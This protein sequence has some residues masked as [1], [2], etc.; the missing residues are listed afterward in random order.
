M[1]SVTPA[2]CPSFSPFG[3][4]FNIASN[5]ANV[6][7]TPGLPRLINSECLCEASVPLTT[8]CRLVTTNG[9][10]QSGT[11]FRGAAGPVQGSLAKPADWLSQSHTVAL[12]NPAACHALCAT[13]T[14]GPNRPCSF[15]EFVYMS[16]TT[17]QVTCEFVSLPPL[18]ISQRFVSQFLS[19]PPV[20]PPSTPPTP[21][22]NAT[23]TTLTS[24]SSLPTSTSTTPVRPTDPTPDPQPTPADPETPPTDTLPSTPPPPTNSNRNLVTG[25]VVAGTLT[26][27][28][29]IGALVFMWNARKSKRRQADSEFV[30]T[31]PWRKTSATFGSAAG[32]G[33]GGGATGLQATTRPNGGRNSGGNHGMLVMPPPSS[34][35][36]SAAGSVAG[37]LPRSAVGSL[38]PPQQAPAPFSVEQYLSAGWTMEQLKMYHPELFANGGGY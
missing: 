17:N 37:S 27:L 26:T 23:S 5:P 20:L 36:G 24:S 22:G 18:P 16:S 15:V 10:V 9:N 6:I 30:Y 38:Y 7:A 35:A 11:W 28:A 8:P 29:I 25:L 4:N 32:G 2:V 21:S 3:A 1:A 33:G 12:P 31:L 13:T 19:A 14:L 34:Y